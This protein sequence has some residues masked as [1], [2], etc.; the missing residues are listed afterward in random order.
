MENKRVKMSHRGR[1][2]FSLFK[3]MRKIDFIIKQPLCKPATHEL[4]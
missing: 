1:K 3:I 4:D 2:L